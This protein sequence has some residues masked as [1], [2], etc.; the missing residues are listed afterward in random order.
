MVDL[1]ITPLR[2]KYYRESRPERGSDGAGNANWLT[3]SECR[4]TV[5]SALRRPEFIP[6][7]FQIIIQQKKS[8]WSF[9]NSGTVA[10]IFP[11]IWQEFQ[12]AEA[13]AAILLDPNVHWIVRWQAYTDYRN[14]LAESVERLEKEQAAIAAELA[15]L[16]RIQTHTKAAIPLPDP[17]G[18]KAAFD[19]ARLAQAQVPV[20]RK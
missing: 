5:A 3:E 13:I 16:K 11:D 14:G 4:L 6:E 15:L 9:L 7:S 19:R 1:S 8:R 18:F 12:A 2:F 17:Q 20:A 10:E